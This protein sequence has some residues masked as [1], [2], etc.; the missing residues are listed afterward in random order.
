MRTTVTPKT[1]SEQILVSSA[2]QKSVDN[3]DLKFLKDAKV[4]VNLDY[5]VVGEQQPFLAGEI[6]NKLLKSG[7]K[8]MQKREESNSVI[9][10][11][12]AGIGV[13]NYDLK[14]SIPSFSYTKVASEYAMPTSYVPVTQQISTTAIPEFPFYRSCTQVA[15]A[16][17]YFTA[18]NNVGIP[19]CGESVGK[20][21]R[22]DFWFM[23]MGPIT[24]TGVES[25][26]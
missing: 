9:S 23:G 17:L 19:I 12:S 25:L 10:F 13:D 11:R 18:Y 1:A 24:S 14:V 22:R 7:C 21:V 8:I 3:M 4:F 16:S 5:L 20:V 26:K 6:Q 2:I 15:I